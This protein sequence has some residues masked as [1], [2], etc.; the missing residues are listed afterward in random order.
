MLE[1]P[2]LDDVSLLI[3]DAVEKLKKH[4]HT[5]FIR[6]DI[7]GR[8]CALGALDIAE[9]VGNKS[10]AIS[11]IADHIPHCPWDGHNYEPIY[12]IHLNDGNKVAQWNNQPERTSE[13]VINKFL[14]VAYDPQYAKVPA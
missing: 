8:M 5:K 2:H 10:E 1:K 13:E 9:G 6:K 7:D 12:G 14:E 3:L 11:R 4:G